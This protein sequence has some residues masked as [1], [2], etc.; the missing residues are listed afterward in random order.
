MLDGRNILVTGA[1]GAIGQAICRALVDNGAKVVIHYGR[2]ET[3]AQNLFQSINGQGW[4]LTAD[5]SQPMAAQTLFAEAVRVAGRIDGLVNNAGIRAEVDVTAPQDEWQATWARE[6]QVNLQA[7]VDL[8]REAI[9]HFR[10]HNGGRIVNMASRAGQKGYSAKAM[11]YGAT[12]AALIN[13]TKSVAQSFGPEGITAVAIAPGWVRT[14]MTADLLVQYG[15][16]NVLSDIPV[17]KLADPEEIGE[18]VAFCLRPSQVSL[19]GA[20]FDV[21][22][23][24]YLR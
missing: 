5:L 8:T 2:N 20:V 22:G 6:I 13:L 10:H 18:L 12:K 24:S 9:L 3:A 21:N 4:C 1:T 19:N 11:G 23:A 14:E 7:P 16:S 15:E 17:G